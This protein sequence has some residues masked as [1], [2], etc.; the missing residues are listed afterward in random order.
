VDSHP[1][2]N[3][4]PLIEGEEFERLKTDVS[5][6]GLI[7]SIWLH[8]DGSILDGRNRWRACEATNT[9]A[10]FQTYDGNLSSAALIAFIV[11]LNK[12]RRHLTSS[13]LA[14]CVVKT[15]DLLE[16]LESEARGRQAVG[17][18][19]APQYAD[20]PVVEMFPQLE[21]GKSRDQA[22]ALFGT[23]GRYV[24]DLKSIGE[25]DQGLLDDVFQGTFSV[26]DAK[27]LAK[28]PVGKRE[29]VKKKVV[30]DGK[31]LKAAIHDVEQET[32]LETIKPV[33]AD[34]LIVGDLRQVGGQIPGDS[35]DLIFTDPPYDKSAVKLYSDL[36]QLGKRVLKPGGILMAYSGQMHLPEIMPLMSEHLEYM[37]LC[38]IG[39]SDGATWFKKWNLDNQWKPILMYGK[40]PIAPYWNKFDDFVSGG[41]EKDNHKWQQALAESAHYI[42]ALCPGGGAVLDPFLGSGTTLVAAKQL[43]CQYFG[44]EKDDL[45]A[46]QAEE[47]IVNSVTT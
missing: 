15:G 37:W 14:A 1:I 17:H 43:G 28:L 16:Q 5:A 6:N 2:A 23:N 32:R 8:P 44:I 19:N 30:G 39:H 18:F 42:K 46:R 36:A 3:I 33:N 31:K 45:T 13:Q 38:G 12:E 22:A 20:N 40:P 9:N 25:R 41:R 35:I 10:H 29:R 7:E 21:Q 4:F 24:Q 26:P 27:I 47:R 34:W 11:S